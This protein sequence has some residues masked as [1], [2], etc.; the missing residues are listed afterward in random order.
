MTQNQAKRHASV[1]QRPAGTG[2]A[3]G[4]KGAARHIGVNRRKAIEAM[5]AER[6][7]L[8]VAELAT[9]FGVSEMT[10]RR[11]LE[12]LE[13]RGGIERAHGGALRPE[14]L[15][16]PAMEPSFVARRDENAAAKTA[17]AQA[18]AQ[19]AQAGD[20]VA[21]DVG[22]SVTALAEVLRARADLSVVTHNLHVVAALAAVESGPDLYVLGGHYR[23]TEGSLCG[24]NAAHEL[25]QL[26]LSLAF[27]GVAG[28]G[29]EGLFDYSTEEAEIKRL[30][31]AR[32]PKVCVLCDASKFDRRSLVRVAGLDAIDILV[33]NA[34]PGGALSEAL[35][36][37]GVRVIIAAQAAD[38]MTDTN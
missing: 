9:C 8:S 24:P 26:W 6:G 30:Y 4:T 5:V 18:A 28:L 32:A 3:G 35:A 23:R 12:Q 17:I 15:S 11:D 31:R 2:R 36:A 34:V 33:T 20:V 25:D 16:V 29:P 37:A 21:L 1:A 27:I 38:A 13:K 7:A 19:L 22:S 14:N 10:I